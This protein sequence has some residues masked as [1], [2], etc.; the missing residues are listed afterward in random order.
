MTKHHLFP[1][2]LAITFLLTLV[3]LTAAISGEATDRYRMAS[4]DT[5][6]PT[7]AAVAAAAQVT[8][9]PAAYPSPGEGTGPT[10]TPAPDLLTPIPED[11]YPAG[12]DLDGTDRVGSGE[13][14][15]FGNQSD[16]EATGAEK[17]TATETSGLGS[18]I[19]WFGFIFG[20]V[21]FIAGLFFSIFLSTRDRRADA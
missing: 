18:F 16:D 21:V 7:K 6:T 13:R 1:L 3:A 11:G 9:T 17:A 12:A 14:P 2:L 4:G 20:L 10:A 5:S 8:E 19:L 15:L